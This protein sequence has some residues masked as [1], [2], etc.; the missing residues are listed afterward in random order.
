MVSIDISSAGQ[1]VMSGWRF[2]P[3]SHLWLVE[4]SSHLIHCMAKESLSRVR[5]LDA[6]SVLGPLH[7]S[8]DHGTGKRLLTKQHSRPDL[9]VL[10]LVQSLL[11]CSG[12]AASHDGRQ[13]SEKPVDME[14]VEKEGVVLDSVVCID[15]CPLRTLAILYQVSKS[16][17]GFLSTDKIWSLGLQALHWS[18]SRIGEQLDP[19]FCGQ[20]NDFSGTCLHDSLES[21][22]ELLASRGRH[23]AP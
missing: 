14:D 11:P 12:C 18:Y 10:V 7:L 6:P 2:G 17:P 16:I 20:Q 15:S 3:A 9:R 23:H 4:A 8:G 22:H 13:E 19:S 5:L 21:H 1:H